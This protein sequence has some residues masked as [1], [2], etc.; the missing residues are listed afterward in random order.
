MLGGS[1]SNLGAG[2]DP[3]LTPWQPK[4]PLKMYRINTLNRGM[5]YS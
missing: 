1:E 4:N 2:L 5:V 3:K